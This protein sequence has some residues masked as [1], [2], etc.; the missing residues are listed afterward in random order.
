MIGCHT[1]IS[2]E[3]VKNKPTCIKQGQQQSTGHEDKGLPGDEN[4]LVRPNGV[5][6][7]HFAHFEQ[8][9]ACS[10]DIFRLLATHLFI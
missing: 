2:K 10:E 7:Q 6:K 4:N 9:L 1:D 3:K 5:S 8:S